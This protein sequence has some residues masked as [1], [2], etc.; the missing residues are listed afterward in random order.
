MHSWLNLQVQKL[1]PEELTA[2]MLKRVDFR[3][4]V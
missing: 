2:V 1:R 3:K 4:S